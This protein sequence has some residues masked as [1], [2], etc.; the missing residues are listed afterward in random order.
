MKGSA[1]DI[2]VGDIVTIAQILLCGVLVRLA[3]EVTAGNCLWHVKA[4]QQLSSMATS[5]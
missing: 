3:F 4:T 1:D 2:L 5:I